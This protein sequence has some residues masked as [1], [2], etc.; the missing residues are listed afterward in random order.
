MGRISFPNPL[1]ESPGS[2]LLFEK[3]LPLEKRI[4]LQQLKEEQFNGLEYRCTNV[5]CRESVGLSHLE[6]VDGKKVRE[7]INCDKC[8][9]PLEIKVDV[10]EQ[11]GVKKI[12]PATARA[13]C[14]NGHKFTYGKKFHGKCPTDNADLEY[15]LIGNEK[16]EF[17]LWMCLAVSSQE[18]GKTTPYYE[19]VLSTRSIGKALDVLVAARLLER[20][21]LD[22]VLGNYAKEPEHFIL[23]EKGREKRE[24]YL[25]TI[26]SY[27]LLND[28]RAF[29]SARETKLLSAEEPAQERNKRF[30][31]A[32]DGILVE[33][34]PESVRKS[35][36][37]DYLPA[38]RFKAE[39]R[40]LVKVGAPAEIKTWLQN[41]YADNV[42][43][44]P[45]LLKKQER[46][47]ENLMKQMILNKI[48]ADDYVLARSRQADDYASIVRYMPA[49]EIPAEIKEKILEVRD[50]KFKG[51]KELLRKYVAAGTL[52]DGE[53]NWLEES[54]RNQIPGVQVAKSGVVFEFSITP[55]RRDGQPFVVMHIPTLYQKEIFSQDNK[56]VWGE[57]ARV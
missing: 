15:C 51:T 23:T 3:T 4:T 2:Y 42:G 38:S 25:Q 20:K 6:V 39:L 29:I 46:Q 13:W 31:S 10:V 37:V 54:W 16:T 35:L 56:V 44:T 53:T 21:T 17:A 19:A 47:S 36:L 55:R 24:E 22:V 5:K 45:V 1:G 27:G 43:I 11:G 50:I 57:H 30:L 26:N 14:D 18:I 7:Y 34:V 33:N 32:L 40:A 12:V 8:A 49:E 9:K 48:S 41:W 52:R 28:F